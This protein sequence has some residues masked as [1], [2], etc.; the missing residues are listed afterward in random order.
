MEQPRSRQKK[1]LILIGVLA[2]ISLGVLIALYGRPLWE[3]FSSRDRIEALVEDAGPWGPLVFILL[4]M[5]QVVAAPIPGQ[6]TSFVAGFLF[7]TFWGTVYTM[8]GITIGFT[9]VIV[10]ARKLGRPFVEYFVDKKK[11]EKFDYLAESQGVFIFFLMALLPFFPDDLI[12][13]IAGLTKIRIRTL[14]IVTFLGRLP[15]NIVYA[16]AG[17]G[18]AEANTRIIAPVIGV[19]LV[20]SGLVWW[21]RAQIEQFAQRLNKKKVNK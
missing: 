21:K 6:V 15:G 17:Q 5:V 12:C 18:V 9:L 8:I 10:L 7:G 14:V 20:L 1:K 2:I 3:L 19:G 11:L 4:Q 16:F 13:F